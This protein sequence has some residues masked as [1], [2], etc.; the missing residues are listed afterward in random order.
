MEKNLAND[1]GMMITS[2]DQATYVSKEGK[3]LSVVAGMYVEDLLTFGYL[4]YQ[5]PTRLSLTTF[6]EKTGLYD[7]F[8]LFG[9]QIRTLHDG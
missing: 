2:R 3:K 7:N 5:E 1:R 4:E 8:D 6:E 9:V